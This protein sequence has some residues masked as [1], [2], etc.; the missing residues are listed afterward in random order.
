MVKTAKNNQFFVY[1][2]FT[3]IS[4]LY[5]MLRWISVQLQS[6]SHLLRACSE[7][8][9]FIV[10]CTAL[11]CE[12]VAH[13]LV[14]IWIFHVY[15]TVPSVVHFSIHETGN[16]LFVTA[17]RSC[18]LYPFHSTGSNETAACKPSQPTACQKVSCFNLLISL[19][20]LWTF[21]SYC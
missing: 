10:F 14:E 3:Y 20:I 11:S 21:I 1:I 7:R 9:L 6:C 4:I 15:W 12:F 13:F 17:I 2:C 8:L 18:T 16:N 5:V 19:P